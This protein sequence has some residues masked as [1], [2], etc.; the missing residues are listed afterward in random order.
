[1]CQAEPEE[2]DE[3]ENL[4]SSNL[5]DDH[6]LIGSEGLTREDLDRKLVDDAYLDDFL[7][8]KPFPLKP[9]E[10]PIA[11]KNEFK[12]AQREEKEKQ[13]PQSPS[14]L[15]DQLLASHGQ[16]VLKAFEN[17]DKSIGLA[18]I[19]DVKARFARINN[20]DFD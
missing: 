3:N 10:H 2:P 7:M 1:M 11:S 19:R 14:G 5:I 17:A 15:L 6:Y 13:A 18:N 12:R 20:R 16:K 9:K 8:S 4:D